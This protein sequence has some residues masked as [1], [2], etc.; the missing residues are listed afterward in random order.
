MVKP[1]EISSNRK[2]ETQEEYIDQQTTVVLHGAENIINFLLPKYSTIK[3]NVDNCYDY[4]GPSVV[5]ESKPIW[6]EILKLDK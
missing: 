3:E 5:A 4:L 2:K 6:K 1:P